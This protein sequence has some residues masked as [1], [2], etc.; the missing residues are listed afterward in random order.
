MLILRDLD[1][2]GCVV[3]V[4]RRLG[5]ED[6]RFACVRIAVHAIEA[7]LLADPEALATALR[8]RRARMP[9]DPESIVDPKRCIVDLAGASTR[10]EIRTELRPRRN[11]RAIEGSGYNS[12]LA[13]FVATAWSPARARLVSPSLDRACR[14]IERIVADYR[15]HIDSA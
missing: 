10:Q 2:D 12:F 3:E 4:R 11:S 6:A 7:W 1:R 8:I 14:A 9:N 5:D 15:A 13:A